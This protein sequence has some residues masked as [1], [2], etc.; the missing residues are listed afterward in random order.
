MPSEIQIETVHEGGMRL[1]T[2]ARGHSVTTDYPIRP[3]DAGL[4]PLEL[5]LTALASCAGSALAMLLRKGEQPF[6]ALRVQARGIR[7]DEHPTLLTAIALE[8]VVCGAN[9]DREA[10]Q[11]AIALSEEKLCP[12]WAMLRPGTKLSSSLRLEVPAAVG[13]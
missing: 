6:D 7:R 9:L 10:V 2:Q 1:T 8:Y 13:A 5:V 11:R 4:T 3:G 12:V